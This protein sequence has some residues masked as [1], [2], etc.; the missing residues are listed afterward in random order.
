MILQA[1]AAN[2]EAAEGV[3]REKRE[4]L[5]EVLSEALQTLTKV[6]NRPPEKARDC[7]A[8]AED[9]LE[10]AL[11]FYPDD[12]L[13]PLEPPESWLDLNHMINPY[14]RPPIW[15]IIVERAERLLTAAK[16]MESMSPELV[17]SMERFLHKEK[18]HVGVE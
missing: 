3:R 8:K 17:H 6:V 14:L 15:N 13:E 9:W 7:L 5:L 2:P 1:E 11:N 10:I 4:K 16:T 12:P 18:P